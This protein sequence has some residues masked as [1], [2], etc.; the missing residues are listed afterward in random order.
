VANPV[1][2]NREM[3]VDG[4]TGLL[5]TTPTQWAEA[6]AR[7]A[8]DPTLRR[9]MGA[10]GRELVRQHYNVR[11]WGP[12]FASLVEQV[13]SASAACRSAVPPPHTHLVDLP[14]SEARSG[15]TTDVAKDR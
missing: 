3:I 6:I 12:R 13:A 1:G 8:A 9:R 5:A 14:G 4:Q 15:R 10:A 7:L 2:M 11:A